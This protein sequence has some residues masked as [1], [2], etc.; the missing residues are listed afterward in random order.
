MICSIEHCDNFDLLD[1]SIAV[2][3]IPVRQ[4][5]LMENRNEVDNQKRPF[6]SRESPVTGRV[7]GIRRKAPP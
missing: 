6:A 3:D 1:Q 4:Q 2:A 5:R 7:S